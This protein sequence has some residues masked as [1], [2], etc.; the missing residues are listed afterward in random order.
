MPESRGFLLAGGA[1]LVA[2]GLSERSTEDLDFFT[3]PA[4]G[5]VQAAKAALLQ[6]A[7]DLGWG[8][9]ELQNAETFCRIVLLTPGPERVLV[10]LALDS[11]P[12]RPAVVSVLGPSYA[13]E[14]LAGRKTVA[15]FDRA[16]SRDFFDVY[17]L[18]SRY[19]RDQLLTW[20]AD[21][22]PGFDRSVFIEMLGTLRRIRDED[23]PTTEEE[24]SALRTFFSQWSKDLTDDIKQHGSG[25]TAGPRPPS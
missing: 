17:T 12:G 10:D 3:A 15:L 20:A 4:A 16:E 13:P 22:D 11:A 1:A 18:A 8:W 21:V 2:A 6:R 23:L 25:A 14:E 24:A 9:E 19:G 5:N 7:G